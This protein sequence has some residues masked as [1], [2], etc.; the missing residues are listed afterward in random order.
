MAKVVLVSI[1]ASHAFLMPFS[2]RSSRQSAFTL[3]ELLVV[4]AIIALL[5]AILFPAFARVRENARRSSCQNNLKQIGMGVLQYTQDYDDTMPFRGHSGLALQD[6]LQ[7]YVKSYQIFVCPDNEFSNEHISSSSSSHL[8]YAPNSNIHDLSY[9]IKESG[10]LFAWGASSASSINNIPVS[11]AAISYPDMTLS[12]VESNSPYSDFCP[13][14]VYSI[15]MSYC[16][17]RPCLNSPHLGRGN[18]LFADGHV[19]AMKAETTLKPVNMWHRNHTDFTGQDLA[20]AEYVVNVS[21]IYYAN[22]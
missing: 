22:K 1:T 9:V 17:N 19:K 13:L 12:M 21:S 3:I 18:Y 10:G 4:I 5:A 8:S 14:R 20:N 2:I 7:P 16:H 6:D 11:V 15:D